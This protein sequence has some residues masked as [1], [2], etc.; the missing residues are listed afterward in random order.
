MNKTFQNMDVQIRSGYDAVNDEF[1]VTIGQHGKSVSL[2]RCMNGQP[3]PAD[4][5]HFVTM[6]LTKVYDN[7]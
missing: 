5:G 1:I 7:G 2:M 3:S 4:I 6:Y